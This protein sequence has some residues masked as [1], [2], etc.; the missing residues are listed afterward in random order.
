MSCPV[1][2]CI[3]LSSPVLCSPGSGRTQLRVLFLVLSEIF[4]NSLLTGIRGK[5]GGVA[6]MA[7]KRQI[8]G[9]TPTVAEV[10]RYC[11]YYYYYLLQ[12][13]GF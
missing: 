1:L 12:Y 11:T 13:L 2:S 9:R 8:D 3:V 7:M 10:L 6:V 5:G 4:D